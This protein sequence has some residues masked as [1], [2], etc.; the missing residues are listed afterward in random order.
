MTRS[1]RASRTILLLATIVLAIILP[2]Y[3]LRTSRALAEMQQ[4]Y[5]RDRAS[6]IAD[7]LERLA[8]DYTSNP[9]V[10]EGLRRLEP[11]LVAV[12]CYREGETDGSA[13]LEALSR[14]RELF[15]TEV[16][17]IDNRRIFRAWMP[18]E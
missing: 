12:R 7:R 2:I 15:R 4:I 14:G 6:R 1:S 8:P 5:L 18:F 17:L 9:F 10:L 13:A 3:S 11:G 16:A